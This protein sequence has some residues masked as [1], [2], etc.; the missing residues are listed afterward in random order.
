MNRLTFITLRNRKK[1]FLQFLS[2]ILL[3]CKGYTSENEILPLDILPYE[4]FIQDNPEVLT[5][6]KEALEEKGIV[7]IKG[8]PGYKQKALKFIEK[9][10]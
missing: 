9:A 10:R 1:F 5:L 4:A 7:G 2:S 3:I 6:L 8:V